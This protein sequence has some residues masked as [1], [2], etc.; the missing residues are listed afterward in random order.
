MDPRMERTNRYALGVILFFVALNAFGGSIYG[1]S[2]A[3][4]IPRAWLEGSPFSSYFIPSLVLLLA[5]AIPFLVSGILVFKRH[6]WSAR[7]AMFCATMLTGWIGVQLSMIGYV[8][9][10]QPAM[11]AAAAIIFFLALLLR[12]HEV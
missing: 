3:K 8:S 12:R 10:L 4:D 2:G 6:A 7:A 11:L 9:W 5:I 1:L